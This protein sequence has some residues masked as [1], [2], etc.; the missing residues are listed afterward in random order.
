MGHEKATTCGSLLIFSPAAV[1]REVVGVAN[2]FVIALSQPGRGAT[3]PSGVTLGQES[4]ALIPSS[5]L[6]VSI[7]ATFTVIQVL[8]CL[9]R[10]L[11]RNRR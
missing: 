10:F 7:R 5:T 9:L 6:Q 4:L 1:A 2:V 3:L 11:E 8:L